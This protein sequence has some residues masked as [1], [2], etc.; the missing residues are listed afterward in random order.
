MRKFIFLISLVAFLSCGSVLS[1][2]DRLISEHPEWTKKQIELIKRGEIEVGM[3]KDMVKA[4]W[5]EPSY[6]NKTDSE[7]TGKVTAWSYYRVFGS[8]IKAVSFKEGIVSM[9]SDSH[10]N[11]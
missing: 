5:G 10:P 4:S 9:F 8:N 3:T 1:L 7:Y 11:E 6:I 2:Q